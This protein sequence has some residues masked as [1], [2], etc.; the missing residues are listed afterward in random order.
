MVTLQTDVLIVGFG[1]VGAT[2]ANLL[3]VYGVRTLV[4]VDEEHDASFKQEEGFRYQ[5]RDLA[6][7]QLCAIAQISFEEAAK[8]L[9]P[10][11]PSA[12]AAWRPTPVEWPKSKF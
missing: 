5:A 9:E 4:V 12:P 6:L 2:I 10:P 7:R 8:P 3:G 11:A 1:P